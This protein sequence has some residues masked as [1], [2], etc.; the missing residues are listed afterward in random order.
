MMQTQGWIK[1]SNGLIGGFNESNP[2]IMMTAM[3]SDN[4]VHA[5]ATPLSQML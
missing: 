3:T 1:A 5:L 4:V 2:V